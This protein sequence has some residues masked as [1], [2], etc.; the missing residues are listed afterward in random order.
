MRRLFA[1]R[2]ETGFNG[3]F[4]AAAIAADGPSVPAIWGSTGELRLVR[5]T[6]LARSGVASARVVGRTGGSGT[7]LVAPVTA[8]VQ[9]GRAEL[10]AWVRGTNA[11]L[12]V[13]IVWFDPEGRQVGHRWTSVRAGPRWRRAAVAARPPARAAFARIVLRAHGLQGSVWIDDVSFAWR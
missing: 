12:R 3:G 1:G 8:P 11:A 7:F 5:D 4:E 10:S 2:L 6:T 13:A 9:G